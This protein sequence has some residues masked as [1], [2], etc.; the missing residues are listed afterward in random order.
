MHV[1][2]IMKGEILSYIKK[3]ARDNIIWKCDISVLI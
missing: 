3:D 2:K 1:N